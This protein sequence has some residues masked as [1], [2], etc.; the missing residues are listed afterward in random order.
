MQ[1]R[2][3]KLCDLRRG[4]QPALPPYTVRTD[5]PIQVRLCVTVGEKPEVELAL[6]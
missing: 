1:E 3:I 4:R 6:A 5:D 2:C